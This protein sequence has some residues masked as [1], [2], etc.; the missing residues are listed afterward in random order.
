[1][2][3][4]FWILLWYNINVVKGRNAFADFKLKPT[5]LEKIFQK[6]LKNPL[7]NP[8]KCGIIIMS[9][10]EGAKGGKSTLPTPNYCGANPQALEKIFEKLFKNL[11]TNPQKYG[12]ICNVRK[13]GT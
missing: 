5:Q 6:L 10:G 11:L 2:T 3:I 13:R 4:D 8:Q 9:R 7:T 12:I 1:M